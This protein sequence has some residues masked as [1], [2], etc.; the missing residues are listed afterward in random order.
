MPTP[1]RRFKRNV[2]L[3]GA[4]WV[5]SCILGALGLIMLIAPGS[6][7]R[8]D[9]AN[10]IEVMSPRY[11]TALCLFIASASI[12]SLGCY[13]EVPKWAAPMRVIMSGV[14]AVIFAAF[15][16][17]A[18]DM[19]TALSISFGVALYGVPMI[20]DMFSVKHAMTD[21]IR[22]WRAPKGGT[23]VRTAFG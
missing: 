8:P 18:L 3:N 16:G 13:S 15:L 12:A 17:R 20:A 5:T 14:R 6:F 4:E 2:P 9:L 23:V 7:D 11:W 22:V 21:T 10:F 1:W 19:S